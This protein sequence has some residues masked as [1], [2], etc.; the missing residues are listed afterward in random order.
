MCF[1]ASRT[2]LAEVGAVR[3][4]PQ[5]SRLS[6]RVDRHTSGRVGPA[7]GC[8]QCSGNG[9]AI[10]FL[11]KAH[12]HHAASPLL[13]PA[14][15]D[16]MADRARLRPRAVREDGQPGGL[17]AIRCP[18]G[19]FLVIDDDGCPKRGGFFFVYSYS[20]ATYLDHRSERD[21]GRTVVSTHPEKQ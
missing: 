19:R 21:S 3:S 10:S 8:L 12:V 1:L 20:H 15:G 13:S 16:G 6:A 17:R 14:P 9:C 5:D 2:H 18:L 11:A 7:G 4:H